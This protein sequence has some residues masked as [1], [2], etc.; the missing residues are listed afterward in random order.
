MKLRYITTYAGLLAGAV[1]TLLTA[2]VQAA[3]LGF[4]VTSITLEPLVDSPDSTVNGITYL[5]QSLPISGLTANSVDW[6]P[7]GFPTPVVTLRRGGYAATD[8]FGN[9]ND[10]QVISGERLPGDP[11]TTLRTPQPTTA[12]AALSQNNILL[13]VDNVFVNAGYINGIQTDIERVDFV[14]SSGVKTSPKRAITIFERG[15]N[16]AHDAFQIAPILSIDSAGNPTSYGSL[17]S[18][19]AGWGQTNLRPGGAAGNNLDYTILTN[20]SGAFSNVLSV[21]Q[22]IGGL[23]IPLSELAA[24]STAIYGYSLFAPDVND[25]SN[26]ANLLDWTNAAVFPQNTPNSIGGLDLTAFNAGVVE[27]VPEPASVLGLLALGTLGMG[28]ALKKK[29][30]SD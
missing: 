16:T 5:N 15:P 1:L 4:T 14:I 17:L 3:S 21:S 13:A 29:K 2:P 8:D 18:I 27:T 6:T 10:R 26:P 11:V 24:T 22:Q 23:L 7:G 25:E 20:S 30:A 12:Q 28:S 9:F 19:N